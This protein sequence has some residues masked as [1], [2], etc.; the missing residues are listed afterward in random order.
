MEGEF[1]MD[2]YFSFTWV[3]EN[4]CCEPISALTPIA[5]RETKSP[6]IWNLACIYC[7][8]ED[9]TIISDKNH[10]IA[11]SYMLAEKSL[12]IIAFVCD[13]DWVPEEFEL[14]NYLWRKWNHTKKESKQKRATY[15]PICLPQHLSHTYPW[16]RKRGEANIDCPLC[17]P[18]DEC[19]DR[20]CGR[21]SISFLA[22]FAKKYPLLSGYFWICTRSR[23]WV[24]TL[25]TP[26]MLHSSGL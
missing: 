3:W 2:K 15:T 1:D 25:K 4:P 5:K 16:K 6:L 12:T 14:V 26:S 11:T 7:M 10:H 24:E 8:H 21:G 22:F 19:I 13:S 17:L 9:E 23:V 20:F 18:R